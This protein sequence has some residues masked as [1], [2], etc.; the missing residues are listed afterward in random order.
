M[1]APEV[2]AVAHTRL[3]SS[4]MAIA[5]KCTT[6]IEKMVNSLPNSSRKAEEVKR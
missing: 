6:L 4:K 5:T 2:S 3:S 1:K